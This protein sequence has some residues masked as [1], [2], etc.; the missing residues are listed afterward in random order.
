MKND[1]LYVLYSP[2]PDYGSKPKFIHIRELPN[3]GFTS[4]YQVTKE[5]AEAIERAGTAAGFKGV[6]WSEYLWLDC[7]SYEAAD[8]VEGRLKEFGYEFK[9]YD[10]GGRGVHFCIVCSDGGVLFNG[11]DSIRTRKA[12]VKCYDRVSPSHLLPLQHRQW[13]KENFPECDSSIYT[14]LHPFRLVGTTHSKTGGR[15]RLVEEHPGRALELPPFD[16]AR[17]SEPEGRAGIFPTS[18][19]K[20]IFDEFLIQR[21]ST[22]A[23]AGERHAQLVRLIYALKDCGYDVN[24]A[25]W[26]AGEVNKRFTPPKGNDEIEKALGSIYR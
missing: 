18:G 7:D 6:V 19:G 8:K 20:S 15:K 1:Y 2:R 22:P 26:W 24:I 14:H 4:L 25:R 17:A 21:N 3:E 9:S 12:P 10:T 13:V 16:K 11:G 23:K 5:T